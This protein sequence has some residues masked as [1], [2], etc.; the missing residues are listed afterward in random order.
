MRKPMERAG[1]QNRGFQ[2]IDGLPYEILN[3]IGLQLLAKDALSLIRCSRR[4]AAIVGWS[5]YHSD[6]LNGHQALFWGAKTG[7]LSAVKMAIAHGASPLSPVIDPD[8]DFGATLNR[9]T[10][11]SVAIENNKIE[12]VRYLLQACPSIGNFWAEKSYLL[13]S[14]KCPKLM[15]VLL[16]GGFSNGVNTLGKIDAW[17]NDDVTPL[18][19]AIERR[20]PDNTV[21]TLLKFGARLNSQNV[22]S[23]RPHLSAFHIGLWSD[24]TSVIKMLIEHNA[25]VN[26]AEGPEPWSNTPLGTVL[27]QS[28]SAC[29]D[30]V[31]LLLHHGADP[32]LSTRRPGAGP[33]PIMLAT[34][35]DVLPKTFGRLL[36]KGAHVDDQL[37]F[38]LEQVLLSTKSGI[39]QW[40]STSQ[41]QAV[42][43]TN[44]KLQMLR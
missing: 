18:V 37:K 41:R 1:P 20:H 28:Q 35:P 25:D 36:A 30:I 19:A 29:D 24:R 14:V 32:N 2:F 22:S 17:K 15:E 23:M 33:S 4:C 42:R 12:V 38:E 3:E 39:L 44:Q 21:R 34:S 16:A 6:S 11:L 40:S 5:L 13:H 9:E 8:Y 31:G 10:A 26:E 27:L 7:Q 43:N